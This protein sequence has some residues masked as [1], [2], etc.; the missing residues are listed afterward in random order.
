MHV[1]PMLARVCIVFAVHRC[2]PLFVHFKPL[3]YYKLKYDK[4]TSYLLQ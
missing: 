3:F 2:Q 1:S 4:E